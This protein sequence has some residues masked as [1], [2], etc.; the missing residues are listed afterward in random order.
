MASPIQ[1]QLLCYSTWDPKVKKG[2]FNLKGNTLPRIGNLSRKFPMRLEVPRNEEGDNQYIHTSYMAIGSVFH[3]AS[4]N[5]QFSHAKQMDR[6]IDKFSIITGRGCL[7][8][9][10]RGNSFEIR[11]SRGL[12]NRN[13]FISRAKN[14]AVKQGSV[15]MQFEK[16][17]I[18][19]TSQCFERIY[20]V[21]DVTLAS[22][23]S[24]RRILMTGEIDAVN[25]DDTPLEITTLPLCRLKS[26]ESKFFQTKLSNIPFILHGEGNCV[27]KADECNN[28]VWIFNSAKQ[29]NT[30]DFDFNDEYL[31]GRVGLLLKLLD[32]I[33]NVL[34]EGCWS[35]KMVTENFE[36]VKVTKDDIYLPC[37]SNN[38]V[39]QLANRFYHKRKNK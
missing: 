14:Y 37:T 5:L 36:I 8:N 21:F 3:M 29:F 16:G 15:G 32:K 11:V 24:M 35:G 25:D 13:I 26:N 12:M 34:G 17:I 18:T 33:E 19:A 7:S 2:F 30:S 23:Q 38:I 1:S 6:T 27:L 10:L 22:D 31:A 20:G 39:K 4:L 9:M 28:A